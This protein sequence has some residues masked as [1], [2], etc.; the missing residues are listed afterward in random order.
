VK[1][2][3][4]LLLIFFFPYLLSA[5]ISPELISKEN[6]KLPENDIWSITVDSLGNK[7]FGTARSGLVKYNNS[8][9]K[10]YNPENSIIKG[11]HIGPLFTDT[12]GILWVSASNPDELFVI[13]KDSVKK[14][15]NKLIEELGGVIAI[16][17]KSMGEIYFGGKNG[18]IKFDGST[19]S[20]IK[21]PITDVIVRT[22]DIS[23]NNTIAIGHN[24]GLLVGTE[25]KWQIFEEEKEKL[26]LSVV[27]GLKFIS[28]TTLIIGYGGGFGNGGFSV[29][30]GEQWTNYNKSNSKILDHTVRD[31]E[32]DKKGNYWMATNNGLI[33]F[34]N[35][36]E[37]EPIL[38]REG[39]F[40]NTIL[41][42]SIQ[43][44]TIW[45]AT[46][47]GVIKLNE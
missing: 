35:K 31:I 44:D 19:W 4:I 2:A 42:I 6:S 23:P 45:I 39:M 12:K 22:M 17:Q 13:K 11:N 28:G 43:D 41:D 16:A 33:K 24:N 25:L 32:V 27:R 38:F 26:Q 3:T 37:L 47:F 14:I 36:G 15:S 7:W 8:E 21:L 9:I 34:T 18:V 20:K 40:K 1:K 10:V 30:S 46:N 29:K 5:Q